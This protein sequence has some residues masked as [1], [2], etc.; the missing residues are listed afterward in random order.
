MAVTDEGGPI[1]VRNY[2]FDPNLTGS[3]IIHT[4]WSGRRVIGL[5]EASWGL[6]D[7]MIEFGS[8]VCATSAAR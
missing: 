8:K 4:H 7:G 2:D 1:L 3:E 5:N 6:L